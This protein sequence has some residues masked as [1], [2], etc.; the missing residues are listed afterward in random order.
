MTHTN[1]PFSPCNKLGYQV[2]MEAWF[3]GIWRDG[4][5][6]TFPIKSEGVWTKLTNVIPALGRVRW[7]SWGKLVKTS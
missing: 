3:W 2:M 6:G 5:V 4:P 7:N 1:S